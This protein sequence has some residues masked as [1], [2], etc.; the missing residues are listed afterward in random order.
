MPNA[1]E[2]DK[3]QDDMVKSSADEELLNFTVI[4]D[5]DNNE[6]LKPDE[7]MKD[8]KS[9]EEKETVTKRSETDS[10]DKK[11]DKVSEDSLIITTDDD[12][13]NEMSCDS[14]KRKSAEKSKEECQDIKK[15]EV[16]SEIVLKTDVKDDCKQQETISKSSLINSEDSPKEVQKKKHSRCI[17]V[18]NISKEAKASALKQHFIKFGKVVTAKIVSDGKR[19]FGYLVFEKPSEAE[20]CRRK[21]DDTTFEGKKIS[22]SLTRPK[23]NSSTSTSKHKEPKPVAEKT[24]TKQSLRHRKFSAGRDPLTTRF[25]SRDKERMSSRG[26]ERSPYDKNVVKEYIRETERL[27]RRVMEQEERQREEVR[28]QKKREEEQR[29]LE[30]KLR[31]ERRRLQVERELFEK[32][33]KEVIR[34]DQE[35]RKIEEQKLS[36]LREKTKLEEELRIAKRLEAKKRRE[37]EEAEKIEAKRKNISVSV[38]SKVTEGSYKYDDPYKV[39]KMGKRLSDSVRAPPPPKLT[40]VSK[41][42]QS[43]NYDDRDRS[44][45]SA[46]PD[47]FRKIKRLQP[48]RKIVPDRF[49]IKV[50]TLHM[51]NSYVLNDKYLNLIFVLT[52]Y[53]RLLSII[54]VI[55]I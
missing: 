31:Q 25:P 46:T 1:P 3:E 53:A 16:S 23:I 24:N 38:K 51:P 41:G 26:K 50:G 47:D 33:R 52:H 48:T 10:D 5:L 29:D 30:W 27:K 6:K 54:S 28:R 37:Q 4:D 35:R 13:D 2:K 9:A 42:R 36:I 39:G 49:D 14:N 7:N 20:E 45:R 21:C 22:V 18:D 40:E 55:S 8:K 34:L 43:R 32:E 44:R 19:C 11:F 15:C 17:W 12:L